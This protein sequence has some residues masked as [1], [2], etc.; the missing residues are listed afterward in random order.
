MSRRVLLI[1]DDPEVRE[2]AQ[3][4]LELMAGWQVLAAES[5]AEGVARAAAEQPDVILLD[6]IM[7]DMDG[8]ATLAA[9]R[10]AAAT[11]HIPVVLLSGTV[12]D[13]EAA[14]YERLGAVGVIGKPFD[15]IT[16]ADQ[17]AGLLGWEA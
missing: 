7:P 8:P 5:G 15:A 11:R 2:V 4:S 3:I 6:V 9:L 13:A 10:A 16:L 12:H 17:I 1:D 14:H